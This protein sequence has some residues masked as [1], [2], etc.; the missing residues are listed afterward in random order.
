M[1][2]TK[3]HGVGNDYIYF[4][5]MEKELENP[6]ELSKKLSDRHF[7][8]GGDGIVMILPSKSSRL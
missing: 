6:E 4:N 8:V 5:C 3:M 2:F 1:E 7:G